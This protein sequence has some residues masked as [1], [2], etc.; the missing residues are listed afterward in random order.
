MSENLN[1]YQPNVLI[2]AKVNKVFK[3]IVKNLLGTWSLDNHA[4]VSEWKWKKTPYVLCCVFLE[5]L[6]I[7]L[8]SFYWVSFHTSI[9]SFLCLLSLL[10]HLCFVSFLSFPYAI[11][12][13][14]LLFFL[15]LFIFHLGFFSFFLYNQSLPLLLPSF[16]PSFLSFFLPAFV[17][18][19]SS[20][21]YNLLSHLFLSFILLFPFFIHYL[22]SFPPAAW[23]LRWEATLG[24]PEEKVLLEN[25]G[26]AGWW[27]MSVVR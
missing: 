12:I 20:P 26:W 22:C 15:P 27:L 14:A 5:S 21:F 25:G 17:L 23:S 1:C 13:L 9:S 2:I 11:T 10:I 18:I 7:S 24:S 6:F 19:F 3:E 4:G 8:T 16:L